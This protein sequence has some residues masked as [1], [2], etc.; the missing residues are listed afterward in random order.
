[1][2]QI[3]QSDNISIKNIDIFPL[4]E[5]NLILH[6]FNNTFENFSYKDSIIEHI[7]EVAKNNPDIIAVETDEYSITYNQLITRINKLSNYLLHKN[8]S[9]NN[10]IGIYTT[11]TIDTIIGI[12][13][14]LKINCT[15]VPIDTQYPADRITHMVQTSK[16]K[17]ILADNI[18]SFTSRK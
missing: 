3:L 1:M 18:N 2:N 8:L 4:K 11:R 10:N 12:L 15:Y 5:K 9:E 16:L 14:I 17:Y 7:E 6:D 13:A